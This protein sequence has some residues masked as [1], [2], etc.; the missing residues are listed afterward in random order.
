VHHEGTLCIL[1]PG[2]LRRTPSRRISENAYSTYFVNKGEKRAGV[3][4]PRPFALSDPPYG[5]SL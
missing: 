5:Y 3:S 2:E 4:I 1:P